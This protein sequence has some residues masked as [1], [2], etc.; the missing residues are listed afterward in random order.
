VER[1]NAIGSVG[2]A[3]VVATGGDGKRRRGCR[4]EREIPEEPG[5]ERSRWRER[6]E[7]EDEK[8]LNGKREGLVRRWG[9]RKRERGGKRR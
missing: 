6:E 7:T 3:G 1:E 4:G 5:K 2:D 9:K 8:D